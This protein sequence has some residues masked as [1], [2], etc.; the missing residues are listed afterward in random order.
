MLVHDL[1]A[2]KGA[3]FLCGRYEG[4]DQRVIDSADMMEVSVAIIFCRVVK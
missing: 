3:V 1:V 4:V 2:A